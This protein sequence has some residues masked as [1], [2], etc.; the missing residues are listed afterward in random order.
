[1]QNAILILVMGL[2]FLPFPAALAAGGGD[3]VFTP[4]NIEPVHF[5][6][7]YHLHVRGLKCGACHFQKFAKGAGYEMHKEKIT[8]DGFCGHCHNGLK[9]FDLASSKNCTR[10]HKK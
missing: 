2:V 6:H 7:D 4:Q 8:K 3:I 10:C 5:S 9:A 1:M